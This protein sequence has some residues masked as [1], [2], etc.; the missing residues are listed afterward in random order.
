MH[1]SGDYNVAEIATL[2]NI[3]RPTV[4][5]SLE[6]TTTL[7]TLR[8]LGSSQRTTVAPSNVPAG[9][10]VQPASWSR[11]MSSP[12]SVTSRPTQAARPD[13]L[14]ILAVIAEFEANLIRQRTR[15]GMDIACQKGKLRGSGKRVFT[16]TTGLELI[17]A[18]I[19]R[20]GV[21]RARYRPTR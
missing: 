11:R 1:D 14:Q 21:I 20:S 4:Y 9:S 12:G 7:P 15:E 3:S 17:D 2:F 8:P 18:K 13:V 10:A 5:R 6:R 16:G 19:Y